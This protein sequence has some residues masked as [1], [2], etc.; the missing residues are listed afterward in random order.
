MENDGADPS[1]LLDY[2][3]RKR[4]IMISFSRSIKEIRKD[5]LSHSPLSILNAPFFRP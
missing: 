5:F 2:K 3:T 4:R 1:D